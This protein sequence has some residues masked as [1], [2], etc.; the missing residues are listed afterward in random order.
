MANQKFCW[1]VCNWALIFLPITCTSILEDSWS[2][3]KA[4]IQLIP[5][6]L[7]KRLQI[8]SH[9]FEFPC[10][11]M[12]DL[13]M[14]SSL[15]FE[16]CKSMLFWVRCGC[17]KFCAWFLI[18]SIPCVHDVICLAMPWSLISIEC[19]MC[20]CAHFWVLVKMFLSVDEHSLFMAACVKKTKFR[21]LRTLLMRFSMP[22]PLPVVYLGLAREWLHEELHACIWLARAS[23]NETQSFIICRQ[24][25]SNWLRV[26][27]SAIPWFQM[28]CNI[29]Y[30]PP[31]S[32]P[33]FICHFL[34]FLHL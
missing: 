23:F 2:I 27:S 3:A 28:P 24:S 33:C 31:I 19:A 30:F 12:I 15:S 18:A 14:L 25:H 10:H 21:F 16:S 5:E 17:L 34:I 7:Y 32:Y 20:W 22:N 8:A 6:L 4:S 1:I 9:N 11:I 26:R 29:F 13:S